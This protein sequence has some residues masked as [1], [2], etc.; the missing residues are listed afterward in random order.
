[1]NSRPQAVQGLVFG[2]L[3]YGMWGVFPLFFHQLREIPSTEVLMHRVVWSFVFVLSILLLL[4][5]SRRLR[6]AIFNPGLR[7]GL[8]VSSLLVSFNW[9]VF[10]WAVSNGRVLES[11]LGYFLTPLVSV[12][13]AYVFLN[14]AINRWQWGAILLAVCGVL[15]MLTR[16]GYLPWVS[17]ALAISFG[18]YGLMR[19]QLKVDSITGL[20][21]ETAILLPLALLFW[22]YLG[23]QGQSHFFFN[24]WRDSLLLM[25]SGMVTALPLLLFAAATKRLS[26]TVVGF[27]MYINPSLQFLLALFVLNEAFN[28]D[29]LIG[30][31]FI[32]LALVIFTLGSISAHGEQPP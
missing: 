1:M 24:G 13:L 14:E 17:L 11:S 15:W 25:A 28:L 3:A 10:I 9:L 30:F 5:W 22:A 19:K 20:T 12:F 8:V 18:L 4:G 16:L 31:C 21:L 32:W 27:M 2:F 29:Q 7:R 26:L 23:A 6:Q